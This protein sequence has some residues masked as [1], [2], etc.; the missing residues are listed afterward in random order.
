MN[1][2]CTHLVDFGFSRVLAPVIAV[3]S[4]LLALGAFRH[5]VAS[6]DPI[7]AIEMKR[8]ALAGSDAL[9]E[10]GVVPPTQTDWIIM[11]CSDPYS[12]KNISSRLRRPVCEVS[13]SAQA[14]N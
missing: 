4:V 14:L 6:A 11:D 13:K 1:C 8:Q 9:L 2:Q 7:A 12:E 3:L 5:P 10:R